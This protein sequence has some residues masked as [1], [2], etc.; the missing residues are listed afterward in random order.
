M[1][2]ALGLYHRLP[3]SSR[4]IVASL[5]GYY[6]NWWRYDKETEKLVEQT[7]ERDF[8]SE[9]QWQDWQNERLSYILHRAA[10]QVPFYK[11]I[12]TE[13]RKNG[14]KASWEYLENWRILEKHLYACRHR[15]LLPKIVQSRKCFTNTPAEQ[16]AHLWIYDKKKPRSNNGMPSL[17]PAVVAGM[18]YQEMTAG[19][20]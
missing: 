14:D 7:L 8:W 20:S 19:R 11:N 10:T 13:R 6:L 3:P 4:S 16:P 9:S 15:N 12:W 2:F 17:K 5:R 18:A 1:S